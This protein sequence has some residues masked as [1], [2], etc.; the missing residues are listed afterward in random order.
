MRRAAMFVLLLA[1]AALQARVT[2]VEVTSRKDVWNGRYEVIRGRVFFAVDPANAHNTVVVDLDK[3]PR[4]A[5]GEVE[6]S[7]DLIVLRPK[8]GGNDALFFEVSNRGGNFM[9]RNGEPDDLFFVQRGYT[10]AWVGWQF[11]ARPGNDRVR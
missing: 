11:D 5:Q 1:A 9:L 8:T 4:N 2:R 3:A 7:S 6:Y 10:M